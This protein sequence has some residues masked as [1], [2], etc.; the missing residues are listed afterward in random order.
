MHR[1]CAGTNNRL[2]VIDGSP[3]LTG[4]WVSQYRYSRY[5]YPFLTLFLFSMSVG[6]GVIG[7]I[8]SRAE[9]GSFFGFFM[10]GPLVSWKT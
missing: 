10:L 7:D 2:L 3:V 5:I 6:A 4:R 8:S 1:T 9:R